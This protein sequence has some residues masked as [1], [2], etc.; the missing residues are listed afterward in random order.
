MNDDARCGSK[1]ARWRCKVFF[2]KEWMRHEIPEE[3]GKPHLKKLIM[4]YHHLVA[5][6]HDPG[7]LRG[8]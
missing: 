1:P 7:E 3:T 2:T 8:L 4:M 6:Q 5:I